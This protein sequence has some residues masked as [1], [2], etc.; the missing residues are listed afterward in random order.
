MNAD[1]ISAMLP[2]I[3]GTLIGAMGAYYA[4][5]IDIAILKTQ[6]TAIIS[7]LDRLEKHADN[8][9][10]RIDRIGVGGK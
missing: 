9:H 5:R 2:N 8:A 7:Q 4:V 10:E 3:V 1:F 6:Y